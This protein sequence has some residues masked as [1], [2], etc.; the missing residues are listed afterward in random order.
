MKWE[1][2]KRSK[3]VRRS[4]GGGFAGL[5][6]GGIV[7]III[8]TLMGGNP[9]P[10]ITGGTLAGPGQTTKDLRD[11]RDEFLAVVLQDTED[12]WNEVFKDYGLEYKEPQLVLYDKGVKTRCGSATSQVG[13]FYCSGDE[14]IYIDTSFYDDLK[15]TFKAPGDFAFAY[16][17]A[18]EVGHHVQNQLGIMDKVY[19]QKSSLSEKEFN[20]LSVKL[21][22]QADY[23]A[24]VFA[25]H[26]QGKG[27]LEE[28]DIEEALNAAAGV[29]DDRI[30]EMTTREIRPDKFTHG[31]SEQ[32]KEWFMRG[33][34]Y[35]DIEHS[36][37]FS[38]IK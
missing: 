15:H 17:L 14:T 18:H 30:Q 28:G 19:A 10:L 16:V 20:K 4:S 35:G 11:D 36:D 12:V 23:F 6:L 38:E 34:K 33:M 5:G 22:L 25:K 26:V 24:G 8:V 31:T 9:L 32:R 2:R 3:N 27:Y 1:N 13:P 37:T 21:E 29:G 7:L